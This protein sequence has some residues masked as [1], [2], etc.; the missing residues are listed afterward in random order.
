MKR[1]NIILLSVIGLLAMI[2][3]W[4]CGKYNN[5]IGN[6]EKVNNA[7]GNVQTAYQMRA[8]LIPGLIASVQAGAKNEKEILEN[9]TK[10]RAGIAE[11]KKDIADAVTPE[12]MDNAG[13]K[14]NSAFTL[15]VESYPQIKG[16]EL[17]KDLQV[18]LSGVESRINTARNDYNNLVKDYNISI[19]RFPGSIVASFG[20]FSTKEMFKSTAGAEKGID[21]RGEFKKGEN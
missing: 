13:R 20:G 6:D 5:I 10:A 17:F 8:D 7:W 16:T 18:S 12:Q 19:R 3:F 11:A 4:G 9:V 15:A 14:I 1:S 21:V 2:F